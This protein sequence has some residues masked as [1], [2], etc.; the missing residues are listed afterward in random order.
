MNSLDILFWLVAAC[1]LV[2]LAEHATTRGW[3][4]LG[5][6]LGLGLLNKTSVLWLGA[7][8]AAWLL[9]TDLRAQLKTRG[10]GSPAPRP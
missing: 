6:V 9:L 10:R 8:V 5:V 3:L 4:V 1:V 7:G 2:G